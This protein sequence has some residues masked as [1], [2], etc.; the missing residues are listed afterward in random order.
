[1]AKGFEFFDESCISDESDD[2]GEDDDECPTIRVPKGTVLQARNR[3][4]RA[5]IF[6][7]LGKSFPYEFMSRKIQQLWSK[8]GGISVWDIGFGHYVA[9]F[10]HAGDYERALFEG[11]WLIRGHYIVAEEWRPNFEHGYSEV[12]KIR[13]WVRLPNLPVEYFD[14]DILTTIGDKIGKTIRLDNTTMSGTRGNFA[15]ICVEIDLHKPLL[16]KYRLRRR[17][18]ERMNVQ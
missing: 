14:P 9:K 15:R 18:M 7:T 17:V 1:M 11:P 6:R 2:E 8:H 4:R 16:S 12:N 13:A 10:M 5:L 3:W